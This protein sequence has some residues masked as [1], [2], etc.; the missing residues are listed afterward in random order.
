VYAFLTRF[1]SPASL[2]LPDLIQFTNW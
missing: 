2:I 1:A